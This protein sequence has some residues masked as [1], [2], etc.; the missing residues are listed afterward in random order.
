[1]RIVGNFMGFEKILLEIQ[2][3]CEIYNES[4]VFTTK[5]KNV[6]KCEEKFRRL[7]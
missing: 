4:V 3:K 2:R 5:G 7:E 6:R 1:M